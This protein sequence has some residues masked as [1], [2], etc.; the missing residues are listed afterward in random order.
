M[1]AFNK[2]SL[3][4]G[5][6]PE[7]LLKKT[8]LEIFKKIAGVHL[9]WSASYSLMRSKFANNTPSLILSWNIS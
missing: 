3:G 4:R 5:S 1:K 8:V 2:L 9:Q 6:R 7:L